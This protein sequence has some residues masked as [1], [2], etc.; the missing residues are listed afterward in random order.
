[1]GEP[2]VISSIANCTGYGRT[3]VEQCED[4]RLLLDAQLIHQAIPGYEAVKQS[5]FATT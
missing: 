2:I 1:M 5:V 4:T 3:R